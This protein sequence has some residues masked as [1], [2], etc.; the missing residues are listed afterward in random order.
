M[1]WP[2]FPSS[3]QTT[4][5][6]MQ[7]PVWGFFSA[8]SEA[9]LCP[10]HGLQLFPFR[11]ATNTSL[12]WDLLPLEW[13]LGSERMI[14]IEDCDE[15][16]TEM[17][18]RTG[19]WGAAFCSGFFPLSV[20]QAALCSYFRRSELS[21][22]RTQSPVRFSPW[23]A[24][25]PKSFLLFQMDC[26]ASKIWTGKEEERD[27]KNENQRREQGKEAVRCQ[28]EKTKSKT[29]RDNDTYTRAGSLI[30]RQKNGFAYE[31]RASLVAQMV[32]LSTCIAGDPGLIP[33]SGRCPGEGNGYPHQYSCLENPMDRRA[34][35]ATVHSVAKS[36]TP[37]SP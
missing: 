3:E 10:G 7:D 31:L 34:W 18:K 21:A 19:W 28:R 14:R 4:V 13:A 5:P 16:R 15:G 6:W 23:V 25:C 29:V 32:K 8:G 24:V 12:L 17:E 9:L 36:Q 20:L 37:L 33:V 27:W 2:L 30:W 26:G 35:W 1:Q 22:H 11:G